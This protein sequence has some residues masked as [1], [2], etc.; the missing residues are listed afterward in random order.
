MARA[1]VREVGDD[2]P[3]SKVLE[4]GSDWKGR[5]EQVVALRAQVQQLKAAQV[6]CA[7]GHVARHHSRVRRTDLVS[8]PSH[9]AVRLHT[10]LCTR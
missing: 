10:P 8:L 4:D 7:G 3:L 5:R 1:L 6:R 2:V 9:H